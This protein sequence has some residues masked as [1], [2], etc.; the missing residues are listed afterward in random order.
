MVHICEN[1]DDVT[2]SD[3]RTDGDALNDLTWVPCQTTEL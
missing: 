1:C 2:D 3:R